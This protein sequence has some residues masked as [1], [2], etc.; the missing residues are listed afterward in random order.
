MTATTTTKVGRFSKDFVAIPARLAR[1]RSTRRSAPHDARRQRFRC[2]NTTTTMAHRSSAAM[3]IVVR[4]MRDSRVRFCS[5]TMPSVSSGRTVCMRTARSARVR[6]V[7]II[8][9]IIITVVVL[10]RFRF[11]Y[12][13]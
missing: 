5:P 6:C 4:A 8:I 13:A 7:I 3:F 9:I 2:F 11:V 1:P 10:D 12:C